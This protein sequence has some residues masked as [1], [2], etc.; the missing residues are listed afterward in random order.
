MLMTLVRKAIAIPAPTRIRGVALT[1]VAAIREPLPNAPSSM[2]LRP[3]RGFAPS[4]SSMIAPNANATTAASSGTSAPRTAL[5]T[6]C[7]PLSTSTSGMSIT[8]CL[9]VLRSAAGSRLGVEPQ[10]SVVGQE[11]YSHIGRQEVGCGQPGDRVEGV[12][13]RS[14]V[15]GSPDSHR[16]LQQ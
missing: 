14:Q 11:R 15:R 12:D 4:A 7:S 1:A 10:V 13:R 9:S 16:T 6:G 5:S 2:A 3:S 8:L